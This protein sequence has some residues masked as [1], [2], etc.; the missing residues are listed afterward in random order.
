M[1]NLLIHLIALTI[2]SFAVLPSAQAT[3]S[4]QTRIYAVL[5]AYK[6][7]LN[8]SDVTAVLDLYTQDGVFMAQHNQ[9]AIGIDAIK[10]AYQAVFK[11]IKLDIKFDIREVKVIADDWAF[12]RTNSAGTT[13]INATG[14]K[15]SEGNQELFLLRK[16]RD[17]WKIARYIF[18]TTNPR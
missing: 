7:A 16:T 13:T 6:Q 5:E 1:K 10:A 8:T 15:I 18:S 2:T 12:A 4:A 11:A 9:P 17:G 14:D 3:E